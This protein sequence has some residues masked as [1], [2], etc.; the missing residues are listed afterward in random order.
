MH[1]HYTAH[2]T[3]HFT[4]CAYVY[5]TLHYITLHTHMKTMYTSYCTMIRSIGI[6]SCEVIPPS[7]ETPPQGTIAY[8]SQNEI[9]Y[10]WDHRK[11]GVKL[12]GERK[13]HTRLE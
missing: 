8:I 11:G 4:Y 5:M 2:Y 13:V 7:Y 10:E 12:R 6:Q 3:L 1:R 9:A